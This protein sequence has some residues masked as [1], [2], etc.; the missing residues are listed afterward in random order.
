M[1]HIRGHVV[2]L[3]KFKFSL[4]HFVLNIVYFTSNLETLF[5]VHKYRTFLIILLSLYVTYYV[6]FKRNLIT[7]FNTPRVAQKKI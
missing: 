7:N 1:T 4:E 6:K 2:L 3:P 5:L